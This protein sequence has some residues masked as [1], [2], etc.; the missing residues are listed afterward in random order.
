[1]SCVP[2]PN[3]IENTGQTYQT[4]SC[5]V[6][7]SLIPDP[8]AP[9]GDRLDWIGCNSCPA[10]VGANGTV[11]DFVGKYA[12]PACV[13]HAPLREREKRNPIPNRLEIF[14]FDLR[15]PGVCR[16][17]CCC[18]RYSTPAPAA[19]QYVYQL[20]KNIVY[21]ASILN[22]KNG[23]QFTWIS[24]SPSNTVPAHLRNLDQEK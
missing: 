16:F 4:S 2:F 9:D 20:S 5:A 10:I 14:F 1:M 11:W 21:F 13:A 7:D 19:S 15:S 8:S 3:G 22:H 18:H 17:A 6:I 23:T 24:G 12:P